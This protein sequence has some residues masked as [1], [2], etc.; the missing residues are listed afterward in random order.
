MASG[1]PFQEIMPL[2]FA[3]KT[4]LDTTRAIEQ[5]VFQMDLAS[6]NGFLQALDPRTKVASFFMFLL[7]AA[8]SKGL[9]ILSMIY[10][11]SLSL[12]VASSIPMS[13]FFKRVW[14]FVPLFTGFI[15]LPAIFNVV[16][17]GD[18]VFTLICFGHPVSFGPFTLPASITITR[19]GLVGATILITRVAVSVSLT[20][21]LVLTT[22]WMDLLD[23]LS[24]LKVPQ[25]IILVVA[26]TYRYIH[27]FLRSLEN[28]LLARK[29][30]LF[31][32]CATVDEHGWISSRLGVLV[33]K[34]YH[35]STEVHLA[36]IS[37][38]WSGTPRSL[39]KFQFDITDK[40]VMALSFVICSAGILFDKL[41]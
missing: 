23:A 27:L 35:L 40:F 13:L 31:A 38:G 32:P 19:Q 34:S 41:L 1:G 30:R 16:T 11:L 39:G 18:D 20:I 2:D 3:A 24:V 6:N 25:V 29:S 26:M 22:R 9:F 28:M 8:F 17:P 12:A 14:I 21:L 5:S 15:A 10:L 7:L 36:M 37:R 4:L 33:G